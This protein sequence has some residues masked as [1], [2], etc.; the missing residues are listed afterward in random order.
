[1][2]KHLEKKTELEADVCSLISIMLLCTERLRENLRSV[3]NKG[4]NHK[5][6]ED[7]YSLKTQNSRAPVCLN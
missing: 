3:Q 7:R 4:R 2:P 6:L 1:M 5:C